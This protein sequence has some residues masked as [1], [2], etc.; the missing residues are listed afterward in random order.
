M[1]T[2]A[3]IYYYLSS[4]TNKHWLLLIQV[5]VE[6]VVLETSTRNLATEKI[7]TKQ[8]DC[9]PKSDICKAVSRA[10]GGLMSSFTAPELQLR[11]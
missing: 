1:Y 11:H 6:A 4:K 5:T 2:K 10:A 9:S 3:V 7:N 8:T